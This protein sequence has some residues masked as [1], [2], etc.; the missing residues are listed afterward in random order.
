[1]ENMK[2]YFALLEKP[3]ATDRNIYRGIYRCGP[4]YEDSLSENH[5]INRAW[6]IYVSDYGQ[7]LPSEEIALEL[8]K[9]F[10]RYGKTFDIVKITNVNSQPDELLLDSF[11]FDIAQTYWYSLLSW[12]LHWNGE[13]DAGTAPLRSLL[14]LIEA[15][16]LPLLNENGLFSSWID[17]NFFLDVVESISVLC[18]GTWETPGNDK[19]DIIEVLSIINPDIIDAC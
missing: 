18:P 9:E 16:F 7:E 6:N 4:S 17:A 2:T 12:G 15:H 14:K 5:P 13:V 10:Q 11:G 1:M 8:A 19:F 3:K